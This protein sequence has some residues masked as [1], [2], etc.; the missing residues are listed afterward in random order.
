MRFSGIPLSCFAALLSIFAIA[1]PSKAKETPV[2]FAKVLTY[3]S[4]GLQDYS[5]AAGDLN[6]DGKLD[7]VVVN[8]CENSSDCDDG[9]VDVLL[10]NGDGTFQAPV[11]Y[12]TGGYDPYYVVIADINEDGKPDLIV[13]NW[14]ISDDG[15]NVSGNIAVLL[16]NGDGTFQ[17]PLTFL[18]GGEYVSWIAVADLN[19]DGHLDVVMANYPGSVGVLLGNGD[20][21]F[22]TV[23][24]YGAGVGGAS[25][26]AIGD[27]NGDGVPDLV[28]SNVYANTVSVLLG[29]GDGTFQNFVSY[30]SGMLPR[31]VTIGDMDGDG[32]QDLVVADQCNT[33]CVVPSEGAVAI[34]RG[35]GD[36][37]FQAPVLYNSGGY[38]AKAAMITDVNGDG[39]PDV[40]V[41][42]LCES[43]NFC[44]LDSGSGRVGVLAGNGDGTF[45][46]AA[47]YRSGGTHTLTIVTGDINGD[48]R[49][50][51]VVAN[52]KS[53][54][55]G[56]L[57][58]TFAVKTTIAL[59]SSLNPAQIDQAITFTAT[60]AASRKIPDGQIVTFRVGSTILGTAET[61]DG[62]AS[63]DVSFA[64]AKTYQVKAVYPGGGFLEGSVGAVKEVV[65]PPK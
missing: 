1:A 35:N 25:S 34:M 22:G 38:T 7:V 59:T 43:R 15:C 36:G 17:A 40:V 13:G 37:T 19:G 8:Y 46:P 48:G 23:K 47:S 57:L 29:N 12:A 61:R 24:A 64:A 9:R 16:G 45:Q 3:D 32:K 14:C 44:N 10:G 18:S 11:S 53:N 54:S 21:T 63:L 41:A 52:W 6:G 49:P 5:V 62:V 33:F 60:I 26:V 28:V 31:T 55:V 27:V 51:I 39:V 56:V 65:L 4:G 58:N 50:D 42:N 2:R 30:W 20:G